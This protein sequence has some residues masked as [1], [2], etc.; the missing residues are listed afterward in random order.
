VLVLR[1]IE[2]LRGGNRG[3]RLL[4]IVHG[5]TVCK[6][7]GKAVEPFFIARS[8]AATAQAASQQRTSKL[9]EFGI[10][11]TNQWNSK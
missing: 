11:A 2:T 7:P 3:D 6:G 1:V 9:P 10:Y 4:V 8:R 5:D